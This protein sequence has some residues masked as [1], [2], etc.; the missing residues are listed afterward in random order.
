MQA[1]KSFNLHP[2]LAADTLLAGDLALCRVLLM[3]DARFPW[4]ILVPRQ[5]GLREAYDLAEEDEALLWREATQLGKELMH[6]FGGDKLNIATLGNQVSQLHVH[7]IVRQEADAA[8]PGPIWGVG[9]AQPYSQ[10]Q[11]AKVLERVRSLPE[12]LF[13]SY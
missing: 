9:K 5:D 2:R 4:L 1:R 3:N 12:I 10:Q 13:K 11:L 8:W 7:V 6:E